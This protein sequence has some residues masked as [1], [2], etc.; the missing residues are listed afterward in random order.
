MAQV[1]EGRRGRGAERWRGGGRAG[2]Y[3]SVRAGVKW[4]YAIS[5]DEYLSLQNTHN[6]TKYRVMAV[7]HCTHSTAVVTQRH[8]QA[9]M[10]TTGT[11]SGIQ[12]LRL[13]PNFS[14]AESS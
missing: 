13:N 9:G 6:F 2:G 14:C 7:L 10:C 3:T 4:L 12:Q 1:Q 5:E 8:I 11:L